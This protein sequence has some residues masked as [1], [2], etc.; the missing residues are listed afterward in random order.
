MISGSNGAGTRTG[1]IA[2][3]VPTFNGGPLLS[4][5]VASAAKAGLPA[6]SYEFV[7]SD[8]VS[9]D[10]SVGRLASVDAQGAP[11]TIRRNASNLGRVENWN[12][13][14]QAAEEMGFSYAIFLMVGDILK[15]ASIIR[16]RDRMAHAGAAL[17]LASYEVV[18]EQVRLLRIARR[19]LWR[20]DPKTG[21][22]PERFLTQ[23]LARGA[24]LY[25]PLGANLYRIDGQVRLRFDAGDASHTD[26]VATALFARQAARCVV[27]LDQPVSCWRQRA[28]RFH[29]SM[30]AGQRLADD[31]RVIGRACQDA[32]VE[33]D[34]P[35]IRAT[36]ILRGAFHAEGNL[37]AAWNN[38]RKVVGDGVVSWSWFTRLMLRRL[39]HNTPWLVEP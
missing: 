6:D 3:L 32:H 18:D 8:N 33:P 24:M 5:T 22:S 28:A 37:R 29:N 23:S 34:F 19:I 10:G 1:K 11:I 38:A 13:A 25:G 27:Y 14:L 2:I 35:K 12:C 36:L 15:D 20:G 30:I 39:I 26:Q 16:L 21:I 4:E 7:V 9:D 31:L 17:G